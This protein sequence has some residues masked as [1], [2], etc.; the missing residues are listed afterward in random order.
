MKNMGKIQQ[1]EE[2]IKNLHYN[3]LMAK[4]SFSDAETKDFFNTFWDIH[5]K[6]VIEY[7]KQMA[8]KYGAHL[9]A[10][11]LGAILHDIA[12]LSDE[13]P[14][15]EVGSKK[16]YQMLIE[17]GFNRELAEKVKSIILTHRCRKYPPETLE[18]KIVASAD[19]MAHF[20]PPFYFWVGKYSIKNFVE[21]LDGNMRK[22]KKDYN[23]KIFFK[24]E[25]KM[26]EEQYKM[27]K[28]WFNY[29]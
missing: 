2:E 1:I 6:P 11:W 20:I 5:I 7:S 18:Q 17:K 14:H 26:V 28:N 8:E 29:K 23:Q 3:P 9:E 16:A 12:R 22:V 4:H 10:V 21:I 13:E 19:A 15:D 27:L 24:D 25:K